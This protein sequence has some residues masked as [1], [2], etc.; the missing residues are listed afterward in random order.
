MNLFYLASPYSK[1]PAGRERAFIEAC[2]NAGLLIGAGVPVYSP[3]AHSHPIARYSG[4]DPLDHAIWMPADEP[5]MRASQGLIVLKLESWEKSY[6]IGVE[7]ATFQLAERPIFY[8]EPGFV[9]D[10][11]QRSAA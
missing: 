2:F 4:L 1:Y 3:I 9:P 8:M 5:M 11:L 6:G 7:I 10:K